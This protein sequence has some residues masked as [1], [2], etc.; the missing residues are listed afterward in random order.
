MKL[1]NY[2]KT[3]LLLVIFLLSPICLHAQENFRISEDLVLK[4]ISPGFFLVTHFFPF[5]SNCAI[6]ILPE[7]K[8]MLIDTPH[9]TSGTKD[10]VQWAE[11]SMGVSDFVA[12]ITGWHQDNLGGNAYLLSRGIDIYGPDLTAELLSSRAGELKSMILVQVSG[13]KNPKYYD[14]YRQLEFLPPNRLFPA[15]KGLF[16]EYGGESFEV[17]FP[18][19]SHT[20]DNTVVYIH[21]REILFGGCMI[22]SERRNRLGYVGHANMEDWPGS[23]QKV[24][25]KFINA[26]IVIPGHGPEGG[27]QLLDHTIRVLDDNSKPN[28]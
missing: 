3:R 25:G 13:N 14:S 8:A 15:D 10:L 24:S 28:R 23:I 9:E 20:I 6:M 21:S 26:E 5:G 16:M 2:M 19:E 1:H 4:E 12:I 17:Y 7:N 11:D 22:Y 18:G 27:I